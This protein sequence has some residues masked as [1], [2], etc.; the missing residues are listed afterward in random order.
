VASEASKKIEGRFLAATI[1]V[2]AILSFI[3]LRDFVWYVVGGL[4]LVFAFFPIHRR[5]R[6]VLRRRSVAAFVSFMLVIS[7]VL[8]PLVLVGFM[9]FNDAVN[10]ARNY[11][12]ESLNETVQGFLDQ[13][14]YSPAPREADD[15]GTTPRT[16][17]VAN[18]LGNTIKTFSERLVAALI[19]IAPSLLVGLVISSFVIY[20][21]FAEGELFYSKF[22]HALP[23]PDEIEESLFRE[24]RKVT[25]VVFVGNIL[26][27]VVGG[28]IGALSFIF[29]GVPNAIF[30][31]FIMIILGILPVVGAPL[32]WGPAALW[33]AIQGNLFGAVGIL[34]VNAVLV[35]GYVDN[36]LRPKLI[37]RVANVHPVVV[38]IGVLGG[39]EAFGALGFVIGPLVL[40]IFIA[41]IRA[42]TSWH[43]RWK[44]RRHNGDESYH[45]DAEI[46][47]VPPNDPPRGKAPPADLEPHD[48]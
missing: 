36:I 10:F 44:E 46:A 29:F 2:F 19:A 21:G 40:A 15:N 32:V 42:Y 14:G 12:P 13:F 9:I 47:V 25:Q 27:S 26:V 3:V 23:L 43:P 11:R 18:A 24:I 39:V 16:S 20:Y 7:I 45:P 1:L 4:L 38:L 31:G 28:V 6:K 22:R 8:G 48:A 17:D 37:G 34:V 33:L 30:W 5:L 41:L 35:I